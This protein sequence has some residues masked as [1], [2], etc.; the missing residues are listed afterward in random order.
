MRTTTERKLVRAFAGIAALLFAATG[1]AKKQEQVAAFH[2]LDV[3][4]PVPAYT[5]HTITGDTVHVGGAE[6]PTVLNVW[7]TWC[8]SCEEE[9]AALDSLRRE[10][11]PRGVRVIA[12]SIDNGNDTRVKRFADANHLGMTIAH[13]PAADIE[14]SWAVVGVPTTFVVG[15]DGKLVWRHTGN[16]TDVLGDAQS[17][18]NKA[19]GAGE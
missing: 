14:Q 6:V 19:M 10:Y 2:P 17:A 15:R 1:C 18:I 9:M 5:A 8:T 12:V 7:A 16:I 13:D 3:G 11:G 4:A